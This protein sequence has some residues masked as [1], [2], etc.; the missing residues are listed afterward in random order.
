MEKP[1]KSGKSCHNF[2][3]PYYGLE[4]P[5][6]NKRNQDFLEKWLTPGGGQ[7]IHTERLDYLYK[8]GSKKRFRD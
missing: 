1:R 4:I 8:L 2:Q 6:P 5:F 7:E 3:G